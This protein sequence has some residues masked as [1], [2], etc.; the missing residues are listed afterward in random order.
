MIIM[1]TGLSFLLMSVCVLG[2]V[3]GGTGGEKKDTVEPGHNGKRPVD[4]VKEAF[5]RPGLGK[6]IIQEMIDYHNEVG[7][8]GEHKPHV[9]EALEEIEA[10][11]QSAWFPLKDGLVSSTPN[12]TSDPTH[13]EC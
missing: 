2:L 5:S 11:L 8:T 4:R 9:V 6:R 10:A 1:R 12:H 3:Y 7:N 13:F